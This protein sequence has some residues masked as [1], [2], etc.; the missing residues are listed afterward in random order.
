MRIRSLVSRTLAIACLVTLATTALPSPASAHGS[1]VR[2]LAD[3][4]SSPK[5]LA[6]FHGH[7]VVGQ[8]AF[9]PPGPVILFLT[10]HRGNAFP[11]ELTEPLSLTDIAVN[12]RDGSGWGIGPGSV[13]DHVFL[14]HRLPDGTMNEV[15]DITDYQAG[16]P[17]PFDQEGLPKE[18]NPYGLA[19]HPS[20]DALVADAAGNDLI[21]VSPDGHAFTVARFG[22]ESIS[23]DHLPPEEAA[24]LPPTLDSEAVPTSVAIGPRG[25][26]YVGELQGFP[27]RPGT[28]HVWKIDDDAEGATC[29]VGVWDRDCRVYAKGLTAIQDITFNPHSGKLYVYELA[30]D[31]VLAFEAGFETGAFPPAVLLEVSG[32]WRRELAKGQLSQPGGIAFGRGGH[33][34]ATDGMFGDGRL[35]RVSR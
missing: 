5:G 11:V 8:G 25:D 6:T 33:L 3:G 35:V 22:T 13:P 17:D 29:T 24:G 27:F 2:V 18:S 28:S 10:F 15:L 12:Q 21:R 14:H 16:D 32:H 23:T 26:I 31:G 4:L 1:S 19:V 34:Y 20:G 9:G 7:P 30:K